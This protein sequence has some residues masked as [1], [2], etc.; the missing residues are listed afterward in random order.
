M[1]QLLFAHCQALRAEQLGEQVV[2]GKHRG[3][4]LP[5]GRPV[6]EGEYLAI[7]QDLAL[8]RDV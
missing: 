6:L 2:V 1:I 7:D 4:Q 5:V 3:E 8:L